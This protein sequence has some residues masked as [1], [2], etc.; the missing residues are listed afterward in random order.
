MSIL[1]ILVCTLA[2]PISEAPNDDLDEQIREY[3]RAL[4]F[5]K[6]CIRDGEWSKARKAIAEWRRIA[7]NSLLSK[8]IKALRDGDAKEHKRLKDWC[9]ARQGLVK[10]K[11][12]CEKRGWKRKEL[13]DLEESHQRYFEIEEFRKEIERVMKRVRGALLPT[14]E[15]FESWRKKNELGTFE[16]RPTVGRAG[17]HALLWWDRKDPG[18]GFK[19][20]VAE[21]D[22]SEFVAVSIWC[23][24]WK[25]RSSFEL[26][27]VGD[28]TDH[29]AKVTLKRKGWQEVRLRLHGKKSDFDGADTAT[30]TG[31]HT[32]EFSR[33][34]A[35][36]SALRIDDIALEREK[37]EIA[38]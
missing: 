8:K 22:W 26:R 4:E 3:Q 33:D 1:L 32:L 18:A 20:H 16:R 5:A 28:G 9:K 21:G 37:V 38:P 17:S 27:C 29:R 24:S 25:S 31:I 30:W 2:V 35:T 14:I 12:K 10:L 23:Y 34:E 6:Q 36:A 11:S 7:A 13:E 19:I 15:D